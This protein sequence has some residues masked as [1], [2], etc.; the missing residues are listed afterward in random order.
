MRSFR[1]GR[2]THS[3][4]PPEGQTGGTI[5]CPG[6]GHVNVVPAP[7]VTVV[8]PTSRSPASGSGWVGTFAVAAVVVGTVWAGWYYIS[9][10]VMQAAAT[11]VEVSAGEALQQRLLKQNLSRAGDP[12]LNRLF[13][14]KNTRHFGGALPGIEVMWEPGLTAAGG[15][16]SVSLQGMFGQH[17][18]RAVILLN[19]SL[20]GDDAAI[21]RT[22]SHEMVHA[23][24][25]TRGD[26]TSHHGPAFQA[27]LHR[28]LAEGAFEGI[29]ATEDEQRALRAWLDAES[30]RLDEERSIMETR[31]TELERERASVERVVSELNA[32]I[33]SL[34]A[35]R[36]R[37][38][39]AEEIAAVASAKAAYNARAA[40]ANQRAA[41]Y[42]Q[43]V[44]FFKR[45]A[46]RYN[47]MLLY[48]DG[49]DDAAPIAPRP[50]LA[51]KRPVN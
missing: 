22:I 8:A 49:L 10:H 14:D 25:F 27:V 7:R 46:N 45:E 5:A 2:C 28:L 1:C 26:R 31:A 12:I 42:Q 16:E 40:A 23:F 17:G 38:P 50:D 24:L 19:P 9:P 33:R 32:R 3:I 4:E 6:C 11:P 21:A 18:R 29:F 43:A 15:G 20:Q 34:K 37:P 13:Q 47:L 48:P 35:R 44:E 30:Q 36:R 39:P 51:P 41:D